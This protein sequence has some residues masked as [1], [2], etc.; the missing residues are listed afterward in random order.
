M[1]TCISKLLNKIVNASKIWKYVWD[2]T[3]KLDKKLFYKDH[4]ISEMAPENFV[5]F[6]QKKLVFLL[7]I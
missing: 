6:Q 7:S 2:V 4:T 5:G 1:S 3:N